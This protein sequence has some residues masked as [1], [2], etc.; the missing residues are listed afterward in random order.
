[1]SILKP[2]TL[3]CPSCEHEFEVE[4]IES[5][6][7][8]RRPDLRDSI[9][10]G[11]LQ[12]FNCPDC[13]A[14]FRLDPVFNYLDMGRGEW[15]SVQPP[16]RLPDWVAEEDRAT[17]VFDM[18]YGSQAPQTAREIGDTLEVRLVFGWPA[19][20][21]KIAIH[22]AGLDDVVVEVT[23]LALIQHSGGDQLG[24]GV[25]LRLA[26]VTEDEMEFHWIDTQ[27]GV[28]SSGLTAPRTLYQ[29]FADDAE[30]WQSLREELTSG[31]FVDVQKLF[32]G[33][34]RMAA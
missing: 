14:E 2:L 34:G 19:L 4:A 10:D 3:T 9:L 25:E 16:Q 27:T 17:G 31:P 26:D 8:D 7:A 33:D 29:G 1:M 13:D 23:K 30:S 32:I 24:T 20:R 22:A 21:E 18:A 11:T 6:N 15:I 5:V 12:V 28:F